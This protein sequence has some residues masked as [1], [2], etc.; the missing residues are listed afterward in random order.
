MENCLEPQVSLRMPSPVDAPQTLSESCR[1]DED[2]ADSGPVDNVDVPRIERAVREILVALGED[3]TREGL[4]ETPARQKHWAKTQAG[5][6]AAVAG[7]KITVLPAARAALM[8]PQGIAMG[9]FQGAIT[10]P[11]PRPFAV[12]RVRSVISRTLKG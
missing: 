10:T 7:L 1:D 8:P 11:T 6:R 3:P 4:R 12:S 2:R 5:S 9:K